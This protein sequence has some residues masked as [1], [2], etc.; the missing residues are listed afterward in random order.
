MIRTMCGK[1]PDLG[2]LLDAYRPMD[3]P[4]PTELSPDELVKGIKRM[5]VTGGDSR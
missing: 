1:T 2:K 4:K 5:K 3:K